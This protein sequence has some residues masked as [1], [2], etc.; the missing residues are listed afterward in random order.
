MGRNDR[1]GT[2]II[3][4]AVIGS[5][6]LVGVLTM[7][8]FVHAT[9]QLEEGATHANEGATGALIGSVRVQAG[10]G[11]RTPDGGL[12]RIALEVGPAPGA[13]GVPLADLRIALATAQA[14]ATFR[15]AQAPA[16]AWAPILDAA[17]GL[18]GDAPVLSRG[19]LVELTLDAAG[20]AVPLLPRAEASLELTMP[21]ARPVV[22]GFTVPVG[23]PGPQDLELH[24]AP[25]RARWTL[26]RMGEP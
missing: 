21:G 11:Y 7:F 4:P 8:L 25:T 1:G 5:A 17:P 6:V 13:E 14:G 9:S 16:F 24:S 22:V 19:D 18:A 15:F 2:S 26:V 3:G 10:T 12:A 23:L 20:A